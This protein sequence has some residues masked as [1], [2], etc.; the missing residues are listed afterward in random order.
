MQAKTNFPWV[1]MVLALICNVWTIASSTVDLPYADDYGV[2]LNFVSDVKEHGFSWAHLW[3]QQSEHRPVFGRSI[4]LAAYYGAGRMNFSL[5]TMLGNFFWAI[6]VFVLARHAFRRSNG[7]AWI[8]LAVVLLLLVPTHHENALWGIS[9]LAFYGLTAFCLAC[10][11]LMAEQR[12]AAGLAASTLAVLTSA[13]GFLVFPVVCG[14]LTLHREWKRLF[15]FALGGL[16]LAVIFFSGHHAINS[17]PNSSHIRNAPT[18]VLYTLCFLG[19]AFPSKALAILAG[20]IL[21]PILLFIIW[22]ARKD[23]F[24]AMLAAFL[25]TTAAAAAW[26]RSGMGVEQALDSRYSIFSLIALSCVLMAATTAGLPERRISPPMIVGA[27]IAVAVFL[28]LQI[29]QSN[30][31]TLQRVKILTDF[32]LVINR[33]KWNGHL[34]P[35]LDRA[36][37]VGIYDGWTA[38]AA[39]SRLQPTKYTETKTT[40]VALRGYTDVFEGAYLLG[41]AHLPGRDVAK[42]QMHIIA[43]NDTGSWKMPVWRYDRQ[44]LDPTFNDGGHY[45]K[46]GFQIA[47][48]DFALPAG[49]YRLHVLVEENGFQGKLAITSPY[50][51][52]PPPIIVTPSS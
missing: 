18:L 32:Y 48:A 19:G 38:A 20:S 12:I 5:L 50:V 6:C 16:V 13:G 52:A 34:A 33:T 31:W 46:S 4:T 29:I 10:F 37:R 14:D 7:N 27:G 9:G 17:P 40:E 11:A 51:V 3:S 47:L 41:W 21:A 39:T 26:S 43:E 23:R 30:R 22:R 15:I 42:A 28:T 8:T 24:L 35:Y 1:I 45:M 2:L 49:R 44:D 36:K 25:L